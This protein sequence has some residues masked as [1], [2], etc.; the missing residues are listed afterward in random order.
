MIQNLTKKQK[1][2]ALSSPKGFTLVELLVVIAII[3]LLSTIVLV[4]FGPVR[5]Q[6]R[7]TAIK[8]NLNQMR[9]AAEIYYGAQ[10]DAG[11]CTYVTTT[12]RTDYIAAK[13][14]VEDASPGTVT[15]NFNASSYCMS[16]NLATNASNHWCI[17]STGVIK[18]AAGV[19]NVTT[20]V[21]P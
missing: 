17:D 10:C 20:F 19:C 8:A 15:A 1:G 12:S 7:D 3:G 9:L 4:S 13:A 14:A 11:T 16:A 18:T 6:A 2:L 5:N 21:C